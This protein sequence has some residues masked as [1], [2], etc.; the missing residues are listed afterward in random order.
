MSYGDLVRDTFRI[1]LRNRFLW[2][3]GFFAGSAFF[4]FPSGGGNFDTD[5]FEQSSAASS[6]LVAQIGPGIFDNVAFIVGIIVVVLL[7][8][9]IFLVMSVISQGLSPRAWPP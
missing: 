7:I 3:F 2:F 6:A 8:L 1:T 9:L 5:D 4:N